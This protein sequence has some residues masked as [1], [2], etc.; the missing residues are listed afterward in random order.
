GTNAHDQVLV[1][2][3]TTH[4]EELRFA[5]QVTDLDPRSGELATHE[6]YAGAIATGLP[7]DAHATVFD[8]YRESDD[9]AR[10]RQ[11]PGS[12]AAL[13]ASRR[14]VAVLVGGDQ[15]VPVADPCRDRLVEVARDIGG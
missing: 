14:L 7:R 11:A 12:R 10:R 2:D 3:L 1:T 4:V 6:P 5:E 9:L 13:L 8:L 15:C